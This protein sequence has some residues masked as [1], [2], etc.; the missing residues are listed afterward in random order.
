MRTA[1]CVLV[2]LLAH[3]AAAAPNDITF[4]PRSGAPGGGT[5][6]HIVRNNSVLRF[7]APQVFFDGVPSPRVTLLNA[8][9]VIAVAPPHAIGI[10]PVTVVDNGGVLGSLAQF[11]FE[12]EL[13]EIIIPIAL[14]LVDGSYGTRW[15]SEISV[16]NESDDSVSID[17]EICY[18]FGS[19][20]LCTGSVRRVAPHSSLNIESLGE[21]S[22][23]AMFVLPPADHA[24]RLHFT[25]RLH[26]ISR[27]PDGVGTEVPVVRARDFKNKQVWLPSVPTTSRFRSTLRVL[28]RG[29]E[30]IV[31]V[32]DDATG[33]LLSGQTTHRYLPTDVDAFGTL[34][35]PGVLSSPDIRARKRVRIE[36]QSNSQVWA[37]L[38]LTDNETQ[39]VQLFTPQ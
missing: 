22:Y 21:S 26:E 31:R 20:H 29:T 11:V 19:P 8:F 27:D 28:T 9:E 7:T 13:E 5:E 38:T 6:V 36:V 15:A 35:L 4:Y 3:G 10:V 17:P 33:A 2:T 39:Q 24:D 1:I 37:I 32:F 25:V 23:P 14:K 30:I 16:Y 34:T 18:S 12:P